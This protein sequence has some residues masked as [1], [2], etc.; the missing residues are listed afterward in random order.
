MFTLFA[1]TPLPMQVTTPEFW[2][3]LYATGQFGKDNPNSIFVMLLVRAIVIALILIGTAVLV[4]LIARITRRALDVVAQ[5][6]EHSRQRL[7]TLYG[8]LTSAFSYTIYFVAVLLILFTCG[9]S[10]AGLAPLPRPAV[11]QLFPFRC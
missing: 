4:T 11:K 5:R 9:V 7:A 1:D 6:S 3:A 10:W 8:L 2:H